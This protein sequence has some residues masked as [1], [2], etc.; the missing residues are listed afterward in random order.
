MVKEE[1]T[2]KFALVDRPFFGLFCCSFLCDLSA[3]SRV[4]QSA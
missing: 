4:T 2:D 1:G 3:N